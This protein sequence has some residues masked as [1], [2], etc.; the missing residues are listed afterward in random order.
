MKKNY[1][2]LSDVELEEWRSKMLE[3]TERRDPGGEH[4]RALRTMQN[5]IR[6]EILT[7][8]KD[9]AQPIEYLASQLDLDAN[10]LEYHLQFLTDIFFIT[11]ESGLV[12][13]TPLG[14][15]YAR[16]VLE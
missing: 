11:V 13:L 8:V 5:P 1:R 3:K 2:D 12:D 10:T 16:N 9:K 14:V 4:R 15:A 6:R 7:L